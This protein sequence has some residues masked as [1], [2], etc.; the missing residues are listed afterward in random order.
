[1]VLAVTDSGPGIP[2]ADLE[3]IFDRFARASPRVSREAGGFGLGLAIVQAIAEA[4]HG[5]VRVR[6]TPGV[7]STFEMVLPLR[8]AVLVVDHLPSR[9]PRAAATS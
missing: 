3:R 7:G 9:R 4:H 1:M 8:P 2:A 6:S 5:S